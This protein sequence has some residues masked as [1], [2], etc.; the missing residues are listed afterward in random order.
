VLEF[1][2]DFSAGAPLGAAVV[3]AEK[4]IMWIYQP[5]APPDGTQTSPFP[6]GIG[7]LPPPSPL[8]PATKSVTLNCLDLVSLDD[9]VIIYLLKSLDFYFAQ[10]SPTSV[11]C[12]H[13]SCFSL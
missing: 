4:K 9:I 10:Q 5:D 6:T 12:T 13:A 1:P 2:I 8:K 7:F 11:F 3:E